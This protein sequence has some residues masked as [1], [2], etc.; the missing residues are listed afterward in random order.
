MVKDNKNNKCQIIDLATYH[1]TNTSVKVVKK[2]S[3]HK[4]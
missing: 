1:L 4:D 3:K 2:L